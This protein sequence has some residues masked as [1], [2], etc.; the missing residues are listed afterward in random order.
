MTKAVENYDNL[1]GP[2]KAA[3]LMMALQDE[4]VSKIMSLL[5]DE[6][7]RELS[8]VMTGLG[9]VSSSTV[10]KLFLEFAGAISAPSAMIG[11]YEK[12]W[13][14]SMNKYWQIT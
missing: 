5:E 2:Q 12:S 13:E 14:I 10:E 1:T 8:I 7:I 4:Q 6:E 9:T 11:N 3:I